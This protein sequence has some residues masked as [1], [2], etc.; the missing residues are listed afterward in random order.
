[1]NSAAEQAAAPDGGRGASE[2]IRNSRRAAAAG[3]PR[4]LARNLKTKRSKLVH[5]ER[6]DEPGIRVGCPKSGREPQESRGCLRRGLDRIRG[7]TGEH[8]RRSR[9]FR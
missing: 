2:L 6:F 7:W 1:M 5:S 3:E 9:S 4:S 8:F